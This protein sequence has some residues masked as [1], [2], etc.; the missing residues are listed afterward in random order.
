MEEDQMSNRSAELNRAVQAVEVALAVHEATW[1]KLGQVIA[2]K[3][4]TGRRTTK[5]MRLR[6]RAS[7]N[8]FRYESLLAEL[9]AA[10]SVVSAPTVA[11]ITEGRQ[12]LQKVKNITVADAAVRPGLDVLV[13]A[14]GKTRDLASGLK[15][16]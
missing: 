12:L 16:S 13:A 6:T 10:S 8:I 14:L 5:E 4:L 1:K 3:K 7:R 15:A 11:E 2:R 9:K